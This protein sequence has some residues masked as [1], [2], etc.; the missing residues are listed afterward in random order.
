[1]RDG[2]GVVSRA[3]VVADPVCQA[4]VAIQWLWSLSKLC[5]AVANPTQTALLRGLFA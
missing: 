3:R 1:M 5:V 4:G 2:G